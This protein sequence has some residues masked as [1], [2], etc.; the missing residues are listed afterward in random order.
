MA[1]DG[2]THALGVQPDSEGDQH[3]LNSFRDK[4]RQALRGTD[5]SSCKQASTNSYD[6][7]VL[8][9]W[10]SAGGFDLVPASWLGC[11]YQSGNLGELT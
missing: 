1:N 4:L 8:Y 10:I 9:C 7:G 6:T 3:R 2:I 5:G 11:R